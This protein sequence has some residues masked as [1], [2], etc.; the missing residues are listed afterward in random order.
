MVFNFLRKCFDCFV[1]F[2]PNFGHTHKKKTTEAYNGYC[3]N[4]LDCESIVWGGQPEVNAICAALSCR[5]RIISAT[6]D[7]LTMGSENSDGSCLD[8]SFHRHEY[9]LGDHY[10]SV[11]PKNSHE[12][13]T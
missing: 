7:P 10:N 5:I 3:T 2:S 11:V 8:L 12:E 1:F 6:G 13:E 4:I 9:G